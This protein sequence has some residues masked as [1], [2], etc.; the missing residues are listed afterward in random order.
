MLGSG[1]WSG[2]PSPSVVGWWTWFFGNCYL[3]RPSPIGCGSG[4]QPQP[5]QNGQQNVNTTGV[6][7]N[8]LTNL[9]STPQPC[10]PSLPYRAA[11]WIGAALG[12]GAGAV[13]SIAVDSLRAPAIVSRKIN[14]LKRKNRYKMGQGPRA[15]LPDLHHPGRFH[16]KALD[17][18]LNENIEAERLP[19]GEATTYKVGTDADPIAGSEHRPNFGRQPW[20]PS[21]PGMTK[22][23]QSFGYSPYAVGTS[24]KNGWWGSIW[25]GTWYGWGRRSWGSCNY[26]GYRLGHHH[27]GL[28]GGERYSISL[29][30]PS[31]F[32]KIGGI[33]SP[34]TNR[35]YP[36]ITIAYDFV[37]NDQ[38]INF[39]TKDFLEL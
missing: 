3:Q 34:L 38:R 36:F 11:Y 8:P 12:L 23:K 32:Q 15:F 26:G 30:T 31:V 35:P 37:D 29:L 16:N 19:V 28:N 9:M 20:G 17:S 39:Q 14:I 4:Y 22:L 2:G 33:I 5:I 13:K 18:G 27:Y 21:P 24:P 25:R 10:V 6:Q 7:L 1:F